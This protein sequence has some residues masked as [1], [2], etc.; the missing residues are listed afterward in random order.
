MRERM[1][2][3]LDEMTALAVY[4]KCSGADA[5]TRIEYGASK[6][7]VLAEKY[8]GELRD[9]SEAREDRVCGSNSG[10]CGGDCV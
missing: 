2:S 8:K 6:L 5:E 4:L 1:V 10:G 9:E 7:A 3:L